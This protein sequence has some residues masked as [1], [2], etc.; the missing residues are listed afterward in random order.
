MARFS[1]GLK[2]AA[3]PSGL[4]VLVVMISKKALAEFKKIYKT[5]FGL[6]LSEA[7]ALA[8]ATRFLNLM[9]VIMRPIPENIGKLS[10]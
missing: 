7:D 9:R 3:S 4:R 2:S 6:E 8:K 10:K 5:E 1:L